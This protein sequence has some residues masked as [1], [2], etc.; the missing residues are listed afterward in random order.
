[1][2]LCGFIYSIDNRRR[3]FLPH[4]DIALE[5]LIRYIPMFLCGF[6]YRIYSPKEIFFQLHRDIAL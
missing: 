4:R 2:F 1:M 5:A 3:N 6:T